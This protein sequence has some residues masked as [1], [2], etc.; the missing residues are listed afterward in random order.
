MLP[1]C[2]PA[3]AKLLAAA[4][5]A[6]PVRHLCSASP[7]YKVPGIRIVPG[8]ALHHSTE[9]QHR[10]RMLRRIDRGEGRQYSTVQY[11]TVFVQ[12]QDIPAETLQYEYCTVLQ[13]GGTVSERRYSTWYGGNFRRRRRRRRR[14][15]PAGSAHRKHM[16]GHFNTLIQ[17]H[18]KA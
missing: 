18:L 1:C 6:A 4:A 11:S 14:R 13:Y 9:L 5:A 2:H 17:S 15:P 10:T 12:Y 7:P 8:R 3:A 16:H